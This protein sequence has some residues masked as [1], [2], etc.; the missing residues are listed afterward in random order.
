M[1]AVRRLT[2]VTGL[3]SPHSLNCSMYMVAI[4]P[5]TSDHA[6][7]RAL[8]HAHERSQRHGLQAW[9]L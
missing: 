5:K 9:A 4:V 1:T 3:Q 7:V 6:A 2:E 8:D